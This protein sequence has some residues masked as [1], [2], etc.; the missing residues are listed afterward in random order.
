MRKAFYLFLVV[1]S[2]VFFWGADIANRTEADDAFEYAWQVEHEGHD[3]LYHPHHLLY[4]AI[5]KDL[6]NGA[7]LLG[8]TGRAYPMLRFVSALCGACTV[9]MF[10]RFCYR[11]FSMRPVSSLLCSGLLLFSY[12]FWRYANEAEV[13]TPACLVMLLALYFSVD[14]KQTS[15]HS[16]VAGVLCGISILF[17]ILNVIPVFVAVPL[18][19]L[20][21]RN[22][23]GFVLN[24]ATA[25]GVTCAGYLWVYYFESAQLFSGAGTNLSLHWSSLVKAAVGFSQCVIS[26]NFMLGYEAVREALVRLFP[27]RMLLEEL[28]LGAVLPRWLVLSASLMLVCVLVCFVCIIA[29]AFYLLLRKEAARR[30]D[31]V[32]AVDG[33]QT[34]VVTLV[35]LAGYAGAVLLLEPGNPEVWVMGLIPFWLVFCGLIVSP[36]SRQNCLWP[37]LLLT[38]LLGLHNYLGGIRPLQIPEGDYNRRKAAKMIETARYGDVVITAGNPVFERYLRYYCPA[39]VEYLHFWRNEQLLHPSASVAALRESHPSGRVFCLG[40]VFN[41]PVSLTRRFPDKTEKIDAFSAEILP[42]ASRVYKDEFGG[43]FILKSDR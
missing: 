3:W 35:W 5:A 2:F 12:G 15:G 33:W 16:V 38:V 18:F 21:Y 30:R 25:T 17:H 32:G 9:L 40:D 14:P 20:L 23:K 6:Y 37:V 34:L 26:S 4:G 41:Q 10:F 1:F 42:M 13:I 22:W 36:L 39:K 43:V 29:V 28:Y 19:Y 31:R 27:A 24:T 11:R 8:Y 7:R